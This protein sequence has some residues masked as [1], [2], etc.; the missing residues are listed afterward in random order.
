M[1]GQ[2]PRPL[3]DG[4]ITTSIRE[5]TRNRYY[6][7]RSC[8]TTSTLAELFSETDRSLPFFSQSLNRIYCNQ[9]SKLCQA[10]FYLVWVERIE[11]PTSCSQSRRS[12]R[13]SYTQIKIKL[14]FKRTINQQTRFYRTSKTLSSTFFVVK[15]TKPPKLLVSGVCCISANVYKLYTNLQ[16]GR[17]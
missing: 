14:T 9:T 15:K 11:L 12:T 1:K 10:F 13:L 3:D 7:C 16:Y 5:L 6:R 17:P 2:C 4:C 8:P